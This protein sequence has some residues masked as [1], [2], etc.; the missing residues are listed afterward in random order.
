MGSPTCRCSRQ[1]VASRRCP[2]GRTRLRPQRPGCRRRPSGSPR[3]WTSIA[4]TNR[5]SRPGRRVH[6]PITVASADAPASTSCGSAYA[7]TRRRRS[8]A[9][10][11]VWSQVDSA[12]ER[13]CDVGPRGH[14][15]R[16]DRGIQSSHATPALPVAGRLDGRGSHVEAMHREHTGDRRQRVGTAGYDDGDTARSVRAAGQIHAHGECGGFSEILLTRLEDGGLRNRFPPSTSRTRVTSSATSRA[17]IGDHASGPAAVASASSAQQAG[18]A[19]QPI[20][21]PEPPRRSWSDRQGHDG[22]PSPGAAG[23]DAPA[24]PAVRRRPEKG[25]AAAQLRH[26]P[27]PV[28]LWS[29]GPPFPRSW[30]RAASNNRSGRDTRRVKPAATAAAST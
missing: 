13:T 23:D 28:S 21:P 11:G 3:R 29:P 18:R 16:A 20:P 22:W 9:Q 5:Y 17:R 30:N 1:R 8:P 12:V 25:Q 24:A 7:M 6:G 15:R 19:P 2:R 27:A 14:R 26:D 10:R 4:A